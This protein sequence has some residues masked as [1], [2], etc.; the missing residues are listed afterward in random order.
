[1]ANARRAS[2]GRPNRLKCNP[3]PIKQERQIVE[4]NAAAYYKANDILI[5][6]RRNQRA[7]PADDYCRIRALALEGFIDKAK[8]D[9][10]RVIWGC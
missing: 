10:E 8:Y 2:V 6:L 1:M 5:A 9:L 7:I 3:I 4:R